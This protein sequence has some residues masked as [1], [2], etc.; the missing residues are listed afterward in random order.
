M[1]KKLERMGK[2]IQLFRAQPR[3]VQPPQ[4]VF[5][6]K[7]RT[8]LLLDYSCPAPEAWWSHWPS[9]SWEEAK[10]LKSTIKPYKMLKWAQIA[11][12]PDLGTVQEIVTDLRRGC[13]L[14][15]RG[16]YL[17]PSTSTNAPSA[18][19]YG[20]RVTDSIVDGIKKGIM[21][22]P[23]T[24]EQIPFK[25]EG[26]KVSG[27]MVTLKANGVARVILNMSKGRPFCVN[28]GMNNEE[29]FEV[30]MSSTKRWLRALHKAGL[31]C[32]MAKLDWAGKMR[33]LSILLCTAYTTLQYSTVQC[34]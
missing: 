15:T 2:E 3:V 16:V 18:Y 19:E 11:G 29:R 20:D 27:I 6:S 31:G 26:I 25:E 9:L 12:H 33:A 30:S 21:M 5:V 22:G 8:P 32:W 17:C 23:M 13:D 7:H 24:K 4:K 14:G 34:S 10:K 1:A 28:E